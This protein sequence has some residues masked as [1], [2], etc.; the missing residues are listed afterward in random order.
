MQSLPTDQDPSI[1]CIFLVVSGYSASFFQVR[2]VRVSRFKSYLLVLVA[3]R[4][5]VCLGEVSDGMKMNC[6]LVWLND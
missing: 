6:M 5:F 3:F 2:E 4:Y 1:I